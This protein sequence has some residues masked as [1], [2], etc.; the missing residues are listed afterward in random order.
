LFWALTFLDDKIED[1]NFLIG[2]KLY[3]AN[4]MDLANRGHIAKVEATEIWVS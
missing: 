1:L 2:P 3:E 4:W